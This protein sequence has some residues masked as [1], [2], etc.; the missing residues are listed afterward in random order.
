M[1][2]S[3]LQLVSHRTTCQIKG[4]H[5]YLA[6]VLMSQFVV[7]VILCG[8]VISYLGCYILIDLQC[9]LESADASG[10]VLCGAVAALRGQQ[11]DPAEVRQLD[12]QRQVSAV[13][14]NAS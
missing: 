12:L 4:G 3:L 5:Q 13:T 6:D 10:V 9:H 8:L 2:W 11:L 1:A 7:A 14:K